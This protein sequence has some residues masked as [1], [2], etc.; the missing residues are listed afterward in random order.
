MDYLFPLQEVEERIIDFLSPVSDL[1]NILLLSKYYH[2]LTTHNKLFIQ[3][4]QCYL[5]GL[6]RE[7]ICRKELNNYVF[8]LLSVILKNATKHGFLKIIQFVFYE[9]KYEFL[10]RSPIYRD[11]FEISCQYGQFKITKWLHTNLNKKYKKIFRYDFS[12]KLAVRGGHSK[13][14]KWLLDFKNRN[15]IEIDIHSD[16]A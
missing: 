6:Q 8:V 3:F 16:S 12:F 10:F 5:D 4:K 15:Q 1:K 9:K 14:I 13:T 11:I 7:I 2:E